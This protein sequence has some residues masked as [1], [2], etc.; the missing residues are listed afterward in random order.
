MARIKYQDASVFKEAN[1]TLLDNFSD[2][3]VQHIEKLAQELKGVL[4]AA[5]KRQQDRLKKVG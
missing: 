1:L 5:K 4:D 3:E 2:D